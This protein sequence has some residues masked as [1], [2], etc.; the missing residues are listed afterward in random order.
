MSYA[1]TDYYQDT[2][3]GKP[4]S[5]VELLQRLLD[6]ASDDLDFLTMGRIDIT[7]MSTA[8]LDTLYKANCAQAEFYSNN[9]MAEA[10]GSASLGS[11][12]YSGDSTG[13]VAY[14]SRATNY[15]AMLG[16]SRAAATVGDKCGVCE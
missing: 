3:A 11:F 2:Y 1:T 8:D 10:G 7:A 9:G 5:D 6:R 15:L 12:S 14:S 16:F 13:S 4:I